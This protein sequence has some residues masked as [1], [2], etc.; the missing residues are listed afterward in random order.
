MSISCANDLAS[1]LHQ[2]LRKRNFQGAKQLSWYWSLRSTS[3]ILIKPS[4]YIVW[5]I[6]DT[7]PLNISMIKDSFSV[8]DVF[9]LP[10][11]RVIEGTCGNTN[12]DILRYLWDFWQAVINSKDTLKNVTIAMLGRDKMEMEENQHCQLLLP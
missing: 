11:Q 1:K 7:Y 8:I 2:L 4:K 12:A 10:W 6:K 9:T 3:C 5:N